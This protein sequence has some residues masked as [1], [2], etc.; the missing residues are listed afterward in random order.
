MIYSIGVI[1]KNREEK[2]QETKAYQ[3]FQKCHDYLKANA[4]IS[5]REEAINFYHGKQ[6][7]KGK[8]GNLN[9][10]R[11][12]FNIC[13]LQVINK[14]ANIVSVPVSVKFYSN[15]KFQDTTF[16]TNFAKYL[17]KEMKHDK[18]R[19]KATLDALIKG[20]AVQH[21]YY[22]EYKFGTYGDYK[23]G[24]CEEILDFQNLAVSNPHNKDIQAQK[25]VI[26]RSRKSFGTLK[27]ML[28]GDEKKIKAL[29]REYKESAGDLTET[30]IQDSDQILTY[31]KYF[32]INGEVYH[33]LSTQT[34]TI[35]EKTP[36][37]PN[38]I[39]V[40]KVINKNE[41]EEWIALPDNELEKNSYEE[42]SEEKFYRYPVNVLTL[43]D[44][45]ESIYGKSELNDVIPTQKYINQL[46]SM[47]LLNVINMAWDK[48]VVLPNALRNQVI[49]DRS[50]QVLVDY[51]GTGQGIKRLGGMNAMSNGVTQLTADA[52]NLHRTIHQITDLYTGQTDQ[53]DIAASALSQLNN[54]ADKPID[55]L[56]Q[57]LWDWEEEIG[58]TLDLFVRLYFTDQ[59]FNYELSEAELIAG[60]DGTNKFQEAEFKSED[61]KKLKFNVVVEAVQ[62]TKNSELVQEN[63]IQSLFLNGTWSNMNT[64]DREFYI[65]M[66]PLAA[67]FKDEMEALLKKQKQDEIT[68]LQ[69]QLQQV[70]Q[71]NQTLVSA[72]ERA[73]TGIEYLGNMNKSMERTY[74]NE[75]KAHQDDVRVRDEAVQQILTKE[76]TGKVDKKM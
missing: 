30:P 63:L 7:K 69:S 33:S 10:P 25:H 4:Y 1:Q 9:I 58:K 64:H 43:N 72:L 3:E 36:L 62:G 42:Y 37:N 31:L 67:P 2:S 45:D 34:V 51:S 15:N 26:L 19:N 23:G 35:Y 8:K 73:K 50:G 49:D 47:Q 56:R 74:K 39:K 55:I 76:P 21:M 44:S 38:L 5:D 28:K 22:N 32:R 48:Y 16:V 60:G 20:T 75:V 65:K 18:H 53:K 11:A 59:K 14:Q 71:Q 66:S 17:L 27:N 41:D 57:K 52:F 61:Y 6:W 54:Q 13:K 29:E 24:V 12:V 46:W 70:M 68:Q 40:K